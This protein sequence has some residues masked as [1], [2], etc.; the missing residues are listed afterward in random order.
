M[1][2]FEEPEWEIEIA[3]YTNFMGIDAEKARIFTI[4]RW[5]YWG[6]F[7][8]LAGAIW[9]GHE[10]DEAILNCL[11]E[12]IDDKRLKLVPRNHRGRPMMPEARAYWVVAGLMYERSALPSKKAFEEI[13]DTLG[14]SEQNVRRLVTSWRKAQRKAQ[15]NN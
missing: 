11:A 5:M 3:Y 8:P 13:A 2:G 15:H 1:K 9:E 4:L 10:I 12:M 14:M 7:R 6:D